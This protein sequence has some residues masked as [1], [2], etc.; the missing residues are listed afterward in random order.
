[1][2][3]EGVAKTPSN[4]LAHYYGVEHPP[5]QGHDALD[6]GLSV[7]YALQYHLLKTGTLQSEAF[8]RTYRKE[9]TARA[10]CWC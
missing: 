10:G 4:K 3:I 6:D 7:A 2:P 5:L 8:D 9:K 1:M